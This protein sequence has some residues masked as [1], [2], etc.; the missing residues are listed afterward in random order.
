MEDN[1]KVSQPEKKEEGKDEKKFY[2]DQGNEISKAAFKKL[3]KEKK[4]KE[5]KDKKEQAKK[6]KELQN[7]PK[8]K[9]QVEELDPTKYFENRKAWI[10]NEM[11]EGKNPYPHKFHVSITMPELKKKYFSITKKGEFLENE[12]VSIAGRV[13]NIRAQSSSLIFYDIISDDVK[14]QVMCA[15]Q[16]QKD[17]SVE[18]QDVHLHI[19]RGDIIGAIGV[20]GRTIGKEDGE[21]SVRAH[22]ITHLSYCMHML[23]GHDTGLK[24]QETRYRQRYLDLIMNPEVKNNFRTRSNIIKYIRRYLD[25]RDFM[26]VETPM[27]NM[28][29]GGATAKP[30]TTHHNELDMKL[31]LRIAPEL[32]LKMLTVGGFDRV[33]E[34]GKQFR[35]EGIDLT[36]NPEFTTC[37]FYMAYADYDDLM[38]M[39]EELVSGMVFSFFG[40][41]EV[42]Y[43]P[44]GKENKD[45]VRT[46]N[47]KP[48]FKKIS[49]VKGIEDAL[50]VKI[51]ENI[52]SEECRLFLIDLCAKNKVECPDPKTT[53]R[54]L[55]KLCGEYVECKCVDPTFIIEHPQIMSPLAKYHRNIKYLTERFELFVN[56]KEVCN[57]FTEMNDPLKQRNLFEEQAKNKLLGDDEACDVDETFLNALE[58]GLPPTG[59]WGL[60]VDRLTMFLT[61]NINIKEVMLYPAMKPII[62][63]D[64]NQI[65]GSFHSHHNTTNNPTTM[66][67]KNEE[68]KEEKKEKKK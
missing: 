31:F 8:K 15:K 35:N 46:V 47:F 16:F 61:D 25:D 19:K 57:A 44:D 5:E 43:H 53:S 10:E 9:K 66:I 41:Y 59:G 54:L 67:V 52:E 65:Q 1:K 22:T 40:T 37:E 39:T 23:P 27:M 45:T 26:E 28:I 62:D 4:Q 56:C 13:F 30:F 29:A 18:F 33:Y 34:I 49:L 68:N 63:K 14:V 38:N 48:P 51:P 3:E 2:D 64:G 24:D 7:P 60:G 6:D 58:Y 21:F 20:P 11:K 32:Y 12:E 42:K 17:T 36:H 50:G 55:D